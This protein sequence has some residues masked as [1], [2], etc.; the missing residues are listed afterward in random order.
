MCA[1]AVLGSQDLHRSVLASE[2]ANLVGALLEIGVPGI[3]GLAMVLLAAFALAT[4]SYRHSL[5]R[6]AMSDALTGLPNRRLFADRLAHALA[7][8]QRAET[9]P[10]VL[11]LGIDRF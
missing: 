1:G 3:M 10:V 7:A 11:L 2:Q 9:Q 6:Q 5:E 8:S 4:R